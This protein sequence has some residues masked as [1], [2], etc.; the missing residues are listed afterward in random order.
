MSFSMT[1]RSFLTNIQ[2][3]ERDS[4]RFL[5]LRLPP[6]L[7]NQVWSFDLSWPF[8]SDS[9]L[10]ITKVCIQTHA[11]TALLPFAIDTFSIQIR[12]ERRRLLSL[13]PAQRDAIRELCALEY[14]HDEKMDGPIHRFLGLQMVQVEFS[15]SPGLERKAS[16]REAIVDKTKA[17]SEIPDLQVGYKWMGRKCE[18]LR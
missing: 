9:Q 10:S 5:L 14:C 15:A 4:K 8:D 18:H 3:A 16:G 6:G 1:R 11:E 17:R 13:L 7:R 12:L 2:R